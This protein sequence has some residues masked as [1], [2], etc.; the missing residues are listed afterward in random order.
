M[1]VVSQYN[2]DGVEFECALHSSFH[3]FSRSRIH[4]WEYPGKQGI[5][6]NVVS[7]NDSTNF[8]SFLQTLRG[9]DGAQN[10]ILSAAVAVTPFVGSDG[11]AMS[12]V[13]GFAKVLDYI[14]PLSPTFLFWSPLSDHITQRS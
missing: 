8:L 1:D 3:I 4:S 10:L 7:A 5:G 14:G 6:C 2:L 12:D 9:Q 13:S 11:T